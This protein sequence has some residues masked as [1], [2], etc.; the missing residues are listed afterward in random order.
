MVASFRLKKSPRTFLMGDFQQSEWKRLLL[1]EMGITSLI[2]S[3]PR[4]TLHHTCTG[5]RAQC[6]PYP[7]SKL[8]GPSGS[9]P[10][11]GLPQILPGRQEEWRRPSR[12][13]TTC[14]VCSQSFLQCSCKTCSHLQ[15]EMSDKN[16]PHS[17]PWSSL[18]LITQRRPATARQW[19]CC[20]VRSI[21]WRGLGTET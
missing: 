3:L 8:R 7:P 2:T 16:H 14:K 1:L 5:L 9:T 15:E 6:F 20:G 4:T 11:D 12:S 18:L 13:S 17:V 19:Q 10:A 21:I